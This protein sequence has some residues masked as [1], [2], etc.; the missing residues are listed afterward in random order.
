MIKYRIK[1]KEEF[2]EEF[3]KRWNDNIHGSWN[4][5]GH[6]DYLFGSELPLYSYENL[7]C[8]WFECYINEPYFRLNIK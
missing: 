2:I 6:M 5:D 4:D 1:T 7:Q 8:N 3:G